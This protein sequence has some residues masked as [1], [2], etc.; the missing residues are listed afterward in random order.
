MHEGADI[1]ERE[2]R[3]GDRGGEFRE[4]GER[5]EPLRELALDVRL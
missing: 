3:S 1:G 4:L 2:L 5:L